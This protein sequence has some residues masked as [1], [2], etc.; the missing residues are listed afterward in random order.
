MSDVHFAVEADHRGCRVRDLN[1]AAGTL[2]SGTTVAESPLRTGDQIVAGQT[3]FSVVVTGE[4]RLEEEAAPKQAEPGPKSAVHYGQQLELSASAQQLLRDD[5][6]PVA[7][8]D[9]LA[10]HGLFL[11]ALRFL[12]LWLPK[13]VAVKWAGAC[14]Q[15]TCGEHLA[16]QEKES[17]ARAQHW[18]DEPTE[19]HRRAA[20]AAAEAAKY[21]DAASWVALGAFWSGGS[22]AP[23]DLPPVPP[24]ESLTA[25]ALT[26]ALMLAA[27]HGDAS[28]AP[29][30]YRDFVEQG[31]K[32]AQPPPAPR[33]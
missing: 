20:G 13:P 8:L 19:E 26:S 12:A 27:T 29:N 22:L 15:R 31:K 6:T 9:L 18:A 32:V 4:S 17:L 10:A 21:A 24:A 14:V 1:S 23:P 33:A 7:Y 3:T 2:V 16:P 30:R 11:D 28:Q 5:L 25:K